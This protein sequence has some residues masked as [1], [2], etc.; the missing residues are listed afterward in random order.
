MQAAWRKYVTQPAVKLFT[1]ET[2]RPSAIP[3]LRRVMRQ[4]RSFARER[5]FGAMPSPPHALRQ[6]PVAKEGSLPHGCHGALLLVDLEAKLAFKKGH[7]RAHHAFSRRLGPNVDV[8]VISIAAEA[9][10]PPFQLFVEVVE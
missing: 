6:E 3:R 1:S 4:S 8:A 2:I 10:A 7:D 5:L 9:V